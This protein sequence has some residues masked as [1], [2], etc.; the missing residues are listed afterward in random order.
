MSE[1]TTEVEMQEVF[2]QERATREENMTIDFAVEL[3]KKEYLKKL[4]DNEIKEIKTEAKSNGILIKSVNNALKNLK[5]SL[6]EN[7]Q[8]ELEEEDFL[9]Q[10]FKTNPEIVSIINDIQS[11]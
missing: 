11:E 9:L 6:K 2:I 4:I 3:L 10:V 5:R 7:G 8:N 1:E